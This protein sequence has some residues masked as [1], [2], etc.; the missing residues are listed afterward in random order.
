[1]EGW[2]TLSWRDLRAHL[3]D[4]G[5]GWRSRRA[6]WV[7]LYG[8]D[9]AFDVPQSI[10][11]VSME[12]GMTERPTPTQGQVRATRHVEDGRV[13]SGSGVHSGAPP[14]SNQT[15]TKWG[16]QAGGESEVF[17]DVDERL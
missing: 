9:V 15:R 10:A 7:P 5:G 14:P 4:G 2:P 11:P 3:L 13:R 12:V 17:R 6:G 16:K 8:R 1:M